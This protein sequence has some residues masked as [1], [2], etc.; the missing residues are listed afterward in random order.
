[1]KSINH[2][3]LAKIA[4]RYAVKGKSLLVLGRTG[5]GKSWSI[6]EAAIK[7][8]R[9][10]KKEFI[11]W[12]TLSLE[13]KQKI[14]DDPNKYHL[15][16]D[17]RVTQMSPE[18]LR[19][20]PNFKGD[21]VDWKPNMWTL[22][23]SKCSGT[24]FLDEINLAPPSLQATLYQILLEKHVGEIPLHEDVAIFGAGNL[25][26]DR[27]G[28]FELAKPIRTRTGLYELNIPSV[29]DWSK[30]AADYGVNPW[31][32]SF[33]NKNIGKLFIDK[34]ESDDVISPRSWVA[35]SELMEEKDPEDDLRN[36]IAGQ[37]GEGTSLEFVKFIKLAHKIPTP[38]ELLSGKKKVPKEID[39]K[40]A[41]ISSLTEYY[42]QH[43]GNDRIKI[44][45]QFIDLKK[46]FEFEGNP[47]FFFVALR[48][49]KGIQENI[50]KNLVGTKHFKKIAEYSEFLQ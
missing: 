36:Y 35:V 15:F 42:R 17:L 47:E 18:D 14:I 26:E 50:F 32:I 2:T 22:A 34:D 12:N 19:G 44:A 38:K 11:E 1:M 37:L 31:I 41:C 43:K 5:I 48:M 9:D 49:F 6:K 13:E 45:K 33:L 39:L 27:A 16:V 20:L 30:W 10:D 3:E 25:A 24:L 46:D 4:H 40:Y 28:T 23:L 8:A 29:E 21:A 7:K